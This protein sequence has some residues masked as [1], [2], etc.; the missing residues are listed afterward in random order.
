[1]TN[2]TKIRLSGNTYSLVDESAIHSLEGYSTIEQMTAAITAATAALAETIAEADYQN[3]TQVQNAITAA[4]APLATNA[5]L[6]AHTSNGDIHV[7]SAEKSA[8]S[9]KLDV[10]DVADFFDEVGYNE[11]T[12]NIEFKHGSDVK[13]TLSAAPFIKDGMVNNVEVKAVEGV[14]S[15]VITF[16][17]D[18]GKD[19]IAIPISD[20]FDASN[21]YTT[22]QTQS[23][24]EGYTYDKATIDEKISDSGTFDPTQYYNKTATD[25]LL[26]EKQ[27]TLVSGTNIKTVG[28]QS[29]LGSG[30][31]AL[32]TAHVGTGTDSETLIFDFA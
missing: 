10:A 11:S 18:A 22:A 6:T 7:T 2:I 27:A 19:A 32:M 28:T 5:D 23:Y 16:N 1:M 21:Y 14:T 29:V 3:V 9:A 30:N 17:T 31:I 8:W 24:V 25:A 20:I 12:K 4:T 15:L 13:K 26:N